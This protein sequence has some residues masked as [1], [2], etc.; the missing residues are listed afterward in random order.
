MSAPAAPTDALSPVAHEILKI[1]QPAAY[2]RLVPDSHGSPTAA[3]ALR[4]LTP[5]KLLTRPIASPSD[6]HALLSGL[7]LWHD[8]LDESHTISQQIHTPTGSFWHAIMHRREGDFS[9]SKYW[10]ARCPS[11]PVLRS[12]AP[13]AN[14]ILHPLPADK[15]LLRLTKSGWDANAF[16]DLVEEVH[17][18]PADPRHA[19]AVL[20][21]KLEWRLL[22]DHCMRAA[23]GQ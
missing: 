5:E 11:H 7:W 17:R 6:A 16:V 2:T 23:S 22:F 18:S 15:S 3:Q 9:N 14:D 21:Q 1:D 13:F 20:L 12:I 19:T 4:N 8:Y 10:F